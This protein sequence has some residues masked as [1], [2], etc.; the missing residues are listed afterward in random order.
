MVK[1]IDSGSSIDVF[2]CKTEQTAREAC[3]KVIEKHGKALVE[4]YIAGPELTVAILEERALSPIR[5]T[6]SHEFFDYTA[7]YVGNEAKH[8]FDLNLPSDLIERVK[9]FGRTGS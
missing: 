4:Q 1:P 9:R 3:R 2:I 7:K 5:I 6:T 8:E